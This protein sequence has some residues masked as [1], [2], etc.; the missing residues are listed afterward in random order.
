MARIE[1]IGRIVWPL[2]NFVAKWKPTASVI[3]HT[4][5]FAP[6]RSIPQLSRRTMA[7]LV[8]Q[9]V[10]RTAVSCPKK[11][12]YLYAD[13]FTN[14][15]EAELGL[16][17]AKLLRR[18]GYQ[19]E[20]PNLLESGR[21]AISKGCLKH[22]KRI[23]TEN[24]KRLTSLLHSSSPQLLIGIE[25]STILTFRDEYPDLVPAE[26]RN[27]AIRTG[28]ACLLY[29]EFLEH[30]MK[31]GNIC[32]DNFKADKME[33]W[34]HG[35]CHQKAIVGVESTVGVLKTLLK[36]ATV[37]TIPSGCCGMAGSFGYEKE[38]YRESLAIGEMVLFPTIRGIDEGKGEMGRCIPTFVAAPGTSCRQQ[39]LDGTGVRAVHPIEILYKYLGH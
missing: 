11:Q 31:A 21:A 34:L 5:R 3:K 14:Q 7:Q 19:V 28:K 38:H 37:H 22:A 26:M 27:E 13:E 20:I 35:H 18:L 8:K 30:E 17:F 39:I 10:K 23:A 32:P 36:G 6:E 9:D 15:Q 1:Q 4:V 2:Y 16:T 29:D 24:V 33:I 12:V 25:P